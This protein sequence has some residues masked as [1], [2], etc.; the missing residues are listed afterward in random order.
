MKTLVLGGVRSGKSR[1]AENMAADFA[2]PVT[3]IATAHA[4]NDAALA[5][6]IAAHRARRP[7]H[8]QLVEEPRALAACL[9]DHGVPGRCLLVDCLTLWLTNL[10]LS[11]NRDLL[12]RETA[13]LLQAL[14]EISADIIFVS[15]ESSL[16][17]TPLG[18]LTRDYLDAAGALHQTLAEQCDRVMLVVAGL[19][20][21]LKGVT[22]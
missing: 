21:T 18:A 4:G 5:Q 6:R 12:R 15:N 22:P 16:G 17:V 14:P 3:Y 10:L 9:R 7:A 20:F 8:W 19:P 11:E 2:G 13:A 1:L